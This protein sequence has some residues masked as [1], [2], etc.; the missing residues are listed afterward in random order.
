LRELPDDLAIDVWLDRDDGRR[1]ELE[2]GPL[3]K[4]LLARPDAELRMPLDGASGALASHDAEY[5]RIVVRVGNRTRETRSSSDE[6]IVA[7][8]F[9]AAGRATP[10]WDELPY[11]GYPFV[12]EGATRTL[13]L[14]LAYVIL[15]LA[16]VATGLF[17]T[18]S[19]RRP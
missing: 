5:G 13:I 18:R 11:P 14:L 6:E 16:F 10:R 19:R 17:F 9:E 3:A 15:P 4:L 7:C 1:T 12:A 2:R 8:A